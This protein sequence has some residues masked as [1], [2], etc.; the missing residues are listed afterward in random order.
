MPV[1]LFATLRALH[2]REVRALLW[3]LEGGHGHLQRGQGGAEQ[4]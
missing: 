2:L 4:P 1:D 3:A